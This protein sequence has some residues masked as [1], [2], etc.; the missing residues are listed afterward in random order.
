MPSRKRSL[1]FARALKSYRT[2]DGLLVDL[3]RHRLADAA[4]DAK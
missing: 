1:F 4:E 3:A 2:F